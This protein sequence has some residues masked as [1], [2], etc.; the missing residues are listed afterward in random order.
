MNKTCPLCNNAFQKHESKKPLRLHILSRRFTPPF[1]GDGPDVHDLLLQ[2]RHGRQGTHRVGRS[3]PRL[4]R[5]WF[6][7]RHRRPSLNL[8]DVDLAILEVKVGTAFPE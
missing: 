3:R 5:P 8:H 4:Q 2:R 7:S 1:V 6:P